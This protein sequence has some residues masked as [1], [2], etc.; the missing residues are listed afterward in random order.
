[1]IANTVWKW[2]SQ[3]EVATQQF[4]LPHHEQREQRNFIPSQ[5]KPETTN[6][7]PRLTFSPS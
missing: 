7:T 3:L 4:V 5:I 1:M 6:L 2:N